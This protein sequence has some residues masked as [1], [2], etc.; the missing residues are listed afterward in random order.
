MHLI[1]DIY[2]RFCIVITVFFHKATIRIDLIM[3]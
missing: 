1:S 3:F 2:T